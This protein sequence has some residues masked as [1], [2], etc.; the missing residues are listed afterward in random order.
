LLLQER[1]PKAIAPLYPNEL[2]MVGRHK[3]LF[4]KSDASLRILN[5]P[6]TP[7]PEVHLLSNGRYH[8]MI[9]NGGGGYSRWKEL[10]VT[11][12]REDPTRDSWGSFCF[13]RDLTSGEVWS[14][15]YQPTLKTSK[16]YE[17]I[18]SQGRAEF[19]R[20]HENLDTH[21]E[22]T[23]SPED[24]IEL[25]RITMTNRSRQARR[26]EL[27]SYAEVVIAAGAAD[28]AH[29][30]FSNLFVETEIRRERHAILCTRRPRSPGEKPPYLIHLMLVQGATEGETSFETDRSK[31]IGRGQTISTPLAFE[32]VLPLSNSEG[33]VLDPIVSIRRVITLEADESVRIELISG[34]AET[35][36][37]ALSLIEKYQDSHLA[38]R[39]IELAWTHSQVVLRHLN[40]S[41]S[42]AQLYGRLAGALLYASPLRREHAATLLKNNRGQNTLWSY[43]I[44]GD[45]PMVLLY[46]TNPTTMADWVRQ[47]VQA[48]AYWRM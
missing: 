14:T 16:L 15:A 21:T 48:H 28:S 47:L 31:F 30:A 46:I 43:G 34:M 8:V 37:A 39:V 32:N 17:A 40:A 29:P 24:D 3:S 23:V 45:W 42:D 1:V 41:E 13:I 9:T 38:E 6:N 20:R 36:E 12:W 19:R 10:F 25:R 22:I 11:R 4:E 35:K 26:I 5:N 27:T 2:E 44:S 18:F 33:S 7:A